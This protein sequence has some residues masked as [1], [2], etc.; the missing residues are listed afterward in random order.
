MRLVHRR[1]SRRHR[2][3]SAVCAQR[4]HKPGPRGTRIWLRQCCQAQCVVYGGVCRP[5]RYSWRI[6]GTAGH[7][8]AAPAVCGRPAHTTECNM[9]RLEKLQQHPF[10]SLVGLAGDGIML[11]LNSLKCFRYSSRTA[12]H[13]C[14]APAVS[15]RPAHIIRYHMWHLGALHLPPFRSL[16]GLAGGGTMSEQLELLE[17]QL[18]HRRH[19]LP[20]LRCAS[21]IWKG[22]HTP[23]DTTC[24]AWKHGISPALVPYVGPVLWQHSDTHDKLHA[25]A[26]GGE[27]QNAYGVR[28]SSN[29]ST[30]RVLDVDLRN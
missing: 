17:V 5:S 25:C 27:P 30:P 24:G 22:L 12:G 8:C 13:V 26:T 4:Y 28:A 2:C 1:H 16:V 3:H 18:V 21:C 23:S 10:W 15:A 14:A 19:R 6:A 29:K 11:R 7:V 20:C 9:W